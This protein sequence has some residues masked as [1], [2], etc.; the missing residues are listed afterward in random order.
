MFLAFI[1]DIYVYLK[2]HRIDIDPEA[3]VIADAVNSTQEIDQGA[4]NLL[5]LRKMSVDGGGMASESDEPHRIAIK[6][7]N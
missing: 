6:D 3:N 7:E 2:S 4:E 5:N 1:M